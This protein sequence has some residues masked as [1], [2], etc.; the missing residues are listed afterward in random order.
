VGAAIAVGLFLSGCTSAP[1]EIT[2]TTAPVDDQRGSVAP[3]LPDFCDQFLPPLA[4]AA[5][6]ERELGGGRSAQYDAPQAGKGLVAGMTCGYGVRGNEVDLTASGLAHTDETVA[7]AEMRKLIG[8]AKADPTAAAEVP[9]RVAGAR[10]VVVDTASSAT[11]VVL[12]GSRTV[13]VTLRSGATG[14]GDARTSLL[15]IT[16]TVVRGLPRS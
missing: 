5:V 11:C 8:Q 10:G 4:V 2:T 3:A 14:S 16:S 9:V 15:R 1:A 6:L 7:R 13:A 12:D